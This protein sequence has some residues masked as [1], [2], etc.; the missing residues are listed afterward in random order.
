M[1]LLKTT[2]IKI[3]KIKTLI[4]KG[5]KMNSYY[6]SQKIKEH[7]DHFVKGLKNIETEGCVNLPIYS[8]IVPNIVDFLDALPG[9]TG[10]TIRIPL[11]LKSP[12]NAL[13]VIKNGVEVPIPRKDLSWHARFYNIYV[14]RNGYFVDLLFYKSQHE[15]IS[16]KTGDISSADNSNMQ[17]ST[18]LFFRL[19]PNL[20]S[21]QHN[22]FISEYLKDNPWGRDVL[23]NIDQNYFYNGIWEMWGGLLYSDRIVVTPIGVIKQSLDK[24]KKIKD[25]FDSKSTNFITWSLERLGFP[26]KGLTRSIPDIKTLG[27]N[28]PRLQAWVVTHDLKRGSL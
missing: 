24:N 23:L 12:V 7:L 20:E 25:P 14:N 3:L 16:V 5:A 18:E 8:Y 1:L 10:V 2:K 6:V 28:S 15:Q 26:A 9:M 22:F 27:F 13:G 19:S 21:I 17:V 4:K 11:L